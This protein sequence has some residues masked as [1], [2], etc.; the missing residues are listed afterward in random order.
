MNKLILLFSVCLITFGCQNSEKDIR[1]QAKNSADSLI[2]LDNFKKSLIG[3]WETVSFK[4]DVNSVNNTDSSYSLFVGHGEWK[5]KLN[6]KPFKTNYRENNTYE[7]SF[8]DMSDSI[9]DVKRGLWSVFGDT[10]ILMEPDGT[11][12]YQVRSKNNHLQFESLLDWDGD[13][14]E[15]DAYMRVEKRVQ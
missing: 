5:E 1:N 7:M 14:V 12:Q 4:V 11:Y 8:W 13:G 10:L 2:I 9:V 15:D 6:L 3:E